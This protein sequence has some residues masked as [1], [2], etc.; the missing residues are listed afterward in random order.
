MDT[1]GPIPDRG[2]STFHHEQR[3]RRHDLVFPPRF[4]SHLQ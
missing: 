4:P 2:P 1:Y 3:V